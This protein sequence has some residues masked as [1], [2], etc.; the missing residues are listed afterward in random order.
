M[1]DLPDDPP[2]DAAGYRLPERVRAW[3]VHVLTASGALAALL[4]LV[5]ILE[6]Q[7]ALALI[8]LGIAMAIDGIDGPLARRW[9]IREVLPDVDGSVLDHVI[10]YVTYAL[11]PAVFL[12]QFALMPDGWAIAGA[13][14]IMTTSLYCFANRNAKTAD[15]FFQGFPA[16]WNLIVLCFYVLATP[17]WLNVAAVVVCAVL[18]FTPMKFVHPFRVR[19]LRPLTIG[20]T[21]VWSAVTLHLL[22]LSVREDSLIAAAPL[23]YWGFVALCGY[24]FAISVWRSLAGRLDRR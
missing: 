1:T 17:D 6:R 9:R 12:Y 7:P 20:L 21:V 23:A 3:S 13:G 2:G 19:A 14:A 4:S 24:F 5:A 10:D 22:L 16:S 18:T 8:W 15:N 11:I